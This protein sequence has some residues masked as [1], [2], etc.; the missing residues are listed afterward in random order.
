MVFH[1]TYSLYTFV[2]V[3]D[4]DSVLISH[5]EMV[6]GDWRQLCPSI[7]YVEQSADPAPA[8]T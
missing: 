1:F 3:V 6:H 5:Y 8:L 2:S 7:N 4:I